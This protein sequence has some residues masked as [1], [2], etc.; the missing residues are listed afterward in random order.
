VAD[1]GIGEERKSNGGNLWPMI[2]AP[3][4]HKIKKKVEEKRTEAVV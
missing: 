2:D 4:K 1:G 3:K